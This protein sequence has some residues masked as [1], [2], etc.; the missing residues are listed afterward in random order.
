MNSPQ[1]KLGVTAIIVPKV[2]CDLLFAP[3]SLK[4]EWSHLHDVD[5]AHPAFGQPSKV[6]LLLGVYI[7]VEVILQGRCVELLELLLHSKP[8][9]D[10]CLQAP[11]NLSLLS[12]PAD[13]L[14]HVGYRSS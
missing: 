6:D 7:F 8:C 4:D 9:S 11:L 13:R 10:G 3:I 5:L 12:I 14:S 1:T 2:T